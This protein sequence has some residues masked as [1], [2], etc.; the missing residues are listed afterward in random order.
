MPLLEVRDLVVRFRTHDDVVHAVNGVSFTVEPG[1][2]L[3]LVGE[4]GCGKSVTN[5]A[6]LRLLPQPAGRIEGGSA[7]FD[8]TNLTSLPESALRRIRG[9]DIAMIFQD[10]MTSL[11]PVLTIDEQMVET[12]QA[13]RDIGK[14]G[15]RAR[16]MELLDMVGIPEPSQRLRGYPHQLSGGMRQRVMIAM[17][18]SLEPRVLIAD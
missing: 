6:I 17:A 5:L 13:H 15:A 12:I 8:G 16:A 18:L 2:A 11:N 10:P 9:R 14:A 7:V 1:D 4:S 3:G